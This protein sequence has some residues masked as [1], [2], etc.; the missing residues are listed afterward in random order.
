VTA[1]EVIGNDGGAA[2]TTHLDGAADTFAADVFLRMD[3]SVAS[4]EASGPLVMPAGTIYDVLTREQLS[5]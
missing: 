5:S 1:G 4:P 3:A 2:D